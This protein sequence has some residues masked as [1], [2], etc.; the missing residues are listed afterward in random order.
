MGTSGAEHGQQQQ[1]RRQRPERR[2]RCRDRALSLQG[3]SGLCREK[4]PDE[5]DQDRY[6]NL[7]KAGHDA[8]KGGTI[9]I[10]SGSAVLSAR[11]RKAQQCQKVSSRMG[12]ST[13][14]WRPTVEAALPNRIVAQGLRMDIVQVD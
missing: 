2:R 12:I 6:S 8:P 10:T 13:M 11:G 14:P 1:Q 4:A 7:I 3:G 9:H 5:S